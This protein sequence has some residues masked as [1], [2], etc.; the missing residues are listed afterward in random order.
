MSIPEQ[1]SKVHDAIE[2]YIADLP[3]EDGEDIGM[4]GDWL[5]V[6]SM[7]TVDAEGQPRTQYY[8][9]MRGGGMLPHVALGLL[10]VGVDEVSGLTIN[11]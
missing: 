2:G 11:D 5:T 3:S 9:I 7:V 4:L 8:L 1:S 10:Q 6:A